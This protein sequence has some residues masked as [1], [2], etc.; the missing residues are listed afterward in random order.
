MTDQHRQGTTAT[1]LAQFYAYAGGPAANV[2]GL[3]ITISPS[4]GGAAVLGPTSVGVVNESTGLYSYA[5]A[6]DADQSVGTYVVEWNATG[7]I[8]A[9]ET[10][11]VV[12]GWANSY[13]TLALLKDALKITDTG[14]DDLLNQALASAS[15][16]VDAHTGRRFYA[17]SSASARTWPTRGRTV[18]RADGELLL[19]DDVSSLTG[20][21]VEI[22]DGTTWSAVTA[23]FT[24][25]DNALVRGEAITALRYDLGY[26]STCRRVRVTARWGWPAVPEPVVQATLIQAAR[27]FRR[28]DSPEGVTGSAEWGLVRVSRVDPDVQA[29]LA[30]LVQPGF[31]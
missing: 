18:R 5:W 24:E 10:V 1:L 26:W 29:L 14:R 31:G 15:R 19:V 22:G 8:T 4:G 17:D 25:P 28:K 21:V 30:H 13:A 9:S 7:D 16:Q 11:E 12:E 20:L 6:I 3:T 2:S 27:L 23:Y